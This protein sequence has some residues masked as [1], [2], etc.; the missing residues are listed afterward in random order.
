MPSLTAVTA[1]PVRTVVTHTTGARGVAS[2]HPA[3]VV[4]DGVRHAA[5]TGAQFPALVVS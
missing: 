1:R 4:I 5:L 2:A 3:T